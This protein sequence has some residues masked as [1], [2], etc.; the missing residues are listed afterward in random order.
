MRLYSSTV[1]LLDPRLGV[2]RRSHIPARDS[3]GLRAPPTH[4]IRRSQWSS[5]T[6]QSKVQKTTRPIRATVTG[7]I[8][9]FAVCC[10]QRGTRAGHLRRNR[11]A[12]RQEECVDHTLQKT[13]EATRA[14]SRG[15]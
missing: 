1:D 2:V 4:T 10:Q 3:A 5:L 11:R 6:T 15:R 14:M 7:W 8:W 9:H 12:R 13:L